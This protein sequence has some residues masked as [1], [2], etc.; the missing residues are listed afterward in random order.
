MKMHLSD[1]EIRILF[2]GENAKDDQQR[3]RSHLEECS[4]CQVRGETISGQNRRVANQ[5]AALAPRDDESPQSAD[6]AFSLFERDYKVKEDVNMF[7]KMFARKYRFAWV[8][9]GVIAILAVAMAFPQVRAIAN[10]FLGLFRVEQ[11]TVLQV[12]PGELEE[13]LS[14]ASNFEYLLAEDVDIE[15]FGDPQEVADAEQASS[16]AGIPVRL[17]TAIA[18]ERKLGI[19]PGAKATFQVDLPKVNGLLTEIGR[20]DLKLPAELDGAVVTLEFPVA[21]VA[22]YG[23]CAVPEERMPEEGVD[24]DLPSPDLSECTTLTQ[25][26]SPEISAPPGLD[27]AGIGETFLQVLGMS[28]EEAAQFS[29]SVDWTTTLVIPIPRYGAE[30]QEVF[31]D[32]VDGTLI[33]Q[34]Q[35]YN[36]PNYLL[37]WIKDGIVYALAG[38]GDAASAMEIAESL[39]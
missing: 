22:T 26:P 6:Q 38:P 20:P 10:S 21:V 19:Q 23:D 25:F 24:P 30:H 35:R 31:V 33:M 27:I 34:S 32:G 18:G 16:L 36:L 15:E 3:L 2:D 8:T 1:E 14:S 5:L 11:F 12:D 17:P 7:Q 28:P 29:R 37:I 13:Q 9:I 4:S 39:E